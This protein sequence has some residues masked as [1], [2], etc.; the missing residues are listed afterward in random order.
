M[1]KNTFRRGTALHAVNASH[2]FREIC[3]KSG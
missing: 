1:E 3:C 2:L